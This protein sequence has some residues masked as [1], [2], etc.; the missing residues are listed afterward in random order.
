MVKNLLS[1]APPKYF[2]KVTIDEKVLTFPH[3][4]LLSLKELCGG[5]I[6]LA[7]DEFQE[8]MLTRKDVEVTYNLRN[9][10]V[11]NCSIKK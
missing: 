8:I 7:S 6:G 4:M 1:T 2:A 10:L 5:E 9:M 3:S 11:T